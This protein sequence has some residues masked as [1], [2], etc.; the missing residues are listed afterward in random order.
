MSLELIAFISPLIGV[1]FFFIFEKLILKTHKNID[2]RVKVVASLE[3]INL[4]VNYSLSL[5][6]L[7]PL[8]FLIAQFQI[9]SFSNWEV[10][11]YI[12]FISSIL[13]LDFIY[14]LSH[15]LHHTVP[16]LWRLH[17]L[18]HTDKQIDSITTFLHHP[19]EVLS[20][21]MVVVIFAVI[22]DIPTI[23][24]VVY[25]LMS[26]LHSGFTHLN[27]LLPDKVNH[28]LKLFIVTPNF[29]RVHHSIDIKES[30]SNFG[31]TF[32][33][34][35]FLFKTVCLKTNGEFEGMKYGVVNYE[36][37]VK[38]TECFKNPLYRK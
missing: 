25:G 31:N 6:L 19:L 9:F 23:A 3:A 30:N 4:I 17:R 14:Y 36:K 28:Y 8:V 33:I 21:F 34:W 22:F 32:T 27:Q 13:F 7:I 35:D 24:L 38:L 15:R 12:S 37:I 20:S 16:F 26:G 29:H 10:P 11:R 5:F 1:S 2:S 18:H